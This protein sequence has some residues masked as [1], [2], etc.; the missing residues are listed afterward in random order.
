MRPKLVA[1]LLAIGILLLTGGGVFAA[2]RPTWRPAKPNATRAIRQ[3]AAGTGAAAI[4][5]AA[6]PTAG[7]ASAGRHATATPSAT[8]ARNGTG[9]GASSSGGSAHGVKRAWRATS[10]PTVTYTVKPG[11]TLSGIATWFKLHG[12][13]NLYAANRSVIGSDPALILPGERITIS[14]GVMS[15]HAATRQHPSAS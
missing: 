6:S 14:H 13:G 8:H 1:G 10:K 15:L 9:H 2:T 11:D 5:A 3:T 4:A 7:A 12:Y